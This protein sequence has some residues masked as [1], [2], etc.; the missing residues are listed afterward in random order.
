MAEDKTPF[1]LA[2]VQ[3][4]EDNLKGL[5][6]RK[7]EQIRQIFGPMAE[8]VQAFEDDFS[9]IM[10]EAKAGPVS[11]DLAARAKRLRLDIAKVRIG[12]EKARKA[13][14]QE[15]LLAG[16]A[17]DGTNNVLK[18][19]INQT[20]EALLA[21]EEHEARAE[22]ARVAALQEERAEALAPYVDDLEGRNLGGMDAD[23]WEAYLESCQRKHAERQE[24][25]R[26]AE[27]KRRADEAARLHAEA[28]L[29]AAAGLYDFLPEDVRDD[30]PG[31]EQAAFDAA[32]ESAKV[33]KEAEANRVAKLERAARQ[34]APSP[35]PAP[36]V[37]EGADEL[38][39]VL[40]WVDSFEIPDAPDSKVATRIADK[41]A[42]F[43]TWAR[44]VARHE[45]EGGE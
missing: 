14:K 19:A 31:M 35:A 42:D 5:E 21:I 33:A 13:L 26:A 12:A 45:L 23:V 11:K 40:A 18:W 9:A 34:K 43:R 1:A 8:A 32:I 28:R 25:E 37:P 29:R 44:K 16:R 41:F 39:T 36:V 30:L 22:A 20:E 3:V 27:E 10:A 2:T 38:T 17:I 6:P 24:A 7:S 4:D 15:Y